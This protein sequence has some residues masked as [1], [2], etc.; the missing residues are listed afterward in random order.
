MAADGSVSYKYNSVNLGLSS[1]DL[2]HLI[3]FFKDIQYTGKPTA[4]PKTN[5]FRIQIYS[6]KQMLYD[7]ESFSVVPNKSLTIKPPYELELYGDSYVK[8]FLV[9][10]I[11]G[12]GCI[13]YCKRDKTYVL[14]I[15]SGSKKM[16]T[17]ARDKLENFYELPHKKI[18]TY[19]P[20]NHTYRLQ[21]KN[22][23][24]VLYDLK[25]ISPRFLSRK[26][27]KLP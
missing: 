7:L 10:Y 18:Y 13:K 14:D 24:K 15:F 22:A 25:N 16:V 21:G 6:V 27:D 11:D 5:S 19:G 20:T 9:G 4:S 2:E 17:W 12:D 26:W 3:Q 8:A 1:K 23:L